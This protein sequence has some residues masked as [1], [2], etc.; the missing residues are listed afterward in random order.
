MDIGAL[1]TRLCIAVVISVINL[2][3]KSTANGPGFVSIDCGGN[4]TYSDVN[5]ILWTP[6]SGTNGVDGEVFSVS[7][8]AYAGLDKTPLSSIRF[9]RGNQSKYCYVFDEGIVQGKAYLVR[10]S[11]WAGSQLPYRTK[12]A[13]SVNF[14]LLIYADEWDTVLITFPQTSREVNKEIYVFAM[15]ENIE[16]CLSGS[17]ISNSDVPFISSLVLRPLSDSLHAITFSVTYHKSRPLMTVSRKNYGAP[18]PSYYVRYSEGQPAGYGDIYDRIWE[19]DTEG[20]RLVTDQNITVDSNSDWVPIAVMQ[21]ARSE[22]STFNLHFEVASF[23]WYVFYEYI[24]EI[25]A[26]V[27]ASGQRVFSIEEN[28]GIR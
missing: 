7:P 4:S 12:V 13:N 28:R 14:K 22:N 3:G 5:E 16:V 23:S 19:P 1:A 18:D 26:D 20:T 15:R 2:S 17:T 6:D 21:T 10:A 25:S 9:F 24:A 27:T 11:F 8:P